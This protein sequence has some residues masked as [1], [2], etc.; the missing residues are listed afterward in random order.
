MLQLQKTFADMVRA[1]H[2]MRAYT[3][4]FLR[5][6]EVQ[7]FITATAA[8]LAGPITQEVP[9]DLAHALKSNIFQFS[10]FKTHQQLAE[11]SALLRNY[12]GGFKPFEQFLDDVRKIDQTY[13]RGYL[14]A[15]YNLAVAST[16]M[17]VKWKEWQKDSGRCNLQYRTA[18][19]DRVRDEHAALDGITLPLDDPFWSM[20]LPPNGWNCRCTAVRVLK[21]S[22]P[23]SDPRQAMD[24]GLAATAEPQQKIFRFNPGAQKTIF[25]PRHPYF[26]VPEKIKEIVK[27]TAAMAEKISEKQESPILKAENIKEVEDIFRKEFDV[28]CNFAGYDK[29]DIKLLDEYYSVLKEQCERFPAIKDKITFLGTMKGMRHALREAADQEI[30]RDKPYLDKAD[31]KFI[32]DTK[33]KKIFRRLAEDKYTGAMSCY[34]GAYEKYGLE[35]IIFNSRAKK[36]EVLEMIKRGVESKWIPWHCDNIRYIADH[37]FGHF[38]DYVLNLCEDQEFLKIYGQYAYAVEPEKGTGENLS[39]YAATKK[40]EFIAEAW[41]EYCNSEKPRHIAKLVG[42]LVIKRMNERK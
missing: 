30:M 33:L 13:N 29:N 34:K 38:I 7:S 36:K 8:C 35:G 26:K 27:K 15:E 4:K 1:L 3:E 12:D 32:I 10:G 21:G 17:A 2:R 22:C 19:D 42:E 5:G 20:F 11:I 28:Q 18:G 40:E 9:E 14:L 23:E 16:Q 41:A 31:R 37:E 6:P 39:R 25:P 24:A